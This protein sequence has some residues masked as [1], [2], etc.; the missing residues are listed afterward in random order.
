LAVPALI[1]VGNEDAFTTRH[2]AERMR[3]LLRGS[4]LVWL[5]GVG[6]MPNLESPEA[7]NA[8]L[9]RLL[10]RSAAMGAAR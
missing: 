9:I 2:D 10:T 6:H 3:D 1:V 8:A 7:F 5:E 4:E